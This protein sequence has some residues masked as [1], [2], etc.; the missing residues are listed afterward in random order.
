MS[1]NAVY[2][3][4]CRGRQWRC[5]GAFMCWE[6]ELVKQYRHYMVV[7]RGVTPETVVDYARAAVLFMAEQ[8]GR[9]L[10]GVGV[11]EVSTFMTRHCR[12]LTRSQP[13]AS[14]PG[15]GRSWA[16]PCSRD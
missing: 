10:E 6:E 7:E 5:L 13:S 9:D 12:R 14:A 8:V 15:C 16:S 11:G 3:N 4:R 1:L 2:P